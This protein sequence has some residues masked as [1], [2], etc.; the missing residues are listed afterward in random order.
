MCI[1]DSVELVRDYRS[2]PEVVGVANT[3]L[4]GSGQ[5]HVTLRAQRA[6]GPQPVFEPAADDSA[7]ASAVVRWLKNLSLI[8]I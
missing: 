2:T 6:S 7:E 5:R 8:H 3:L 4:A 1:R